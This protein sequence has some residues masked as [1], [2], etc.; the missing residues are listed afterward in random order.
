MYGKINY[1]KIERDLLMDKN[2]TL[3]NITI[4]L[5][6]E[7]IDLH[8]IEVFKQNQHIFP[9]LMDSRLWN[10][11]SYKQLPILLVILYCYVASKPNT[12]FNITE[13]VNKLKKVYIDP[14]ELASVLSICK[15]YSFD[16]EKV[17]NKLF[18]EQF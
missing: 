8:K 16:F 9:T 14:K 17:V 4:G 6:K 10:A 11:F 15:L 13:I 3:D 18:Y 5:A 7:A 1:S 12:L 2:R